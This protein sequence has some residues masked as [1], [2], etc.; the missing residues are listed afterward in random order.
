[1]QDD[2]LLVNYDKLNSDGELLIKKSQ[3]ISEN[4]ESINKLISQK[5]DSW[6]GPDSEAYVNGLKDLIKKING[7]AQ[8][9]EKEGT[10]MQTMASKY[11]NALTNCAKELDANE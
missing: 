9:V 7:Y 2:N 10:Y 11:S 4:I 1:M 5:W 8:E 6:K 3:V